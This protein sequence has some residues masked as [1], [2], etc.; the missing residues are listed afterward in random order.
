M[1]AYENSRMKPN[2]HCLK[3]GRGKKEWDYNGEGELVQGTLWTYME[4]TQ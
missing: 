1:L 2:K 3:E 4:L